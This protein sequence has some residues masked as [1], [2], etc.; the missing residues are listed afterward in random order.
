MKV[1]ILGGGLAGL[2]AANKLLDQKNFEI[3]ILEKAPF[4][5]GLASSF[6]IPDGD[7]IPRFNHHII[8]ANKTTLKYLK[9]Y[10]LL[11]NNTWKRINMG[12]AWK[13]KVYNINKPWKYLFFPY[14]NFWEKIRFGLFGMYVSYFLNPDKL[15]DELDAQAYL[16]KT[17]GK[18]VTQKMYYQLYGRNKFNIPLSQIA[19]KQFAWR[20]KEREFNDKFTYPMKGIQGMIDGLVKDCADR[21]ARMF[22]KA[23]VTSLDVQNKTIT[24]LIDGKEKT[25][26]FDVFI[27]TIPVPELIKFCE[28]LPE[29]YQNQIKRLRYVPVVGLLFGTEDFLDPENYWINIIGERVHVIYQHSLLVDKYKNK[30]T[31][32]IRYGGSEED[33]PKSDEEIKELYLGVLKKY[34]PN[35]KL[36]WCYVF[37]EKYAEPIYDKDYAK[38]AP[39]YRTP[40]KG[41]YNAGIQCT[42]P[43]IRNMNVALESGEHVAKLILED[44]SQA[45]PG[46]PQD[47]SDRLQ[48]TAQQV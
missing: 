13:G 28:G 15:P 48:Q 20:M 7:L 16:N 45:Q 37:R 3:T 25:E 1:L 29:D 47:S 33:I 21:G 5:G 42:F 27:N 24:Y 4:W 44:Y 36:N 40:V 14:L 32:C 35:I 26:T 2:A 11:G 38:Y 18:S 22:L 6:R 41:Y 43:K 30:V 19:M 17:C 34:F 12:V 31:W 10:D 23:N 39:T 8:R 46:K 9:R